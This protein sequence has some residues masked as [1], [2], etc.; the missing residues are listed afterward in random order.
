MDWRGRG[1]E[2]VDTSVIV[3]ERKGKETGTVTANEIVRDSTERQRDKDLSLELVE[4]RVCGICCV[5]ILRDS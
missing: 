5:M 1:I 3:R 2:N 4:A